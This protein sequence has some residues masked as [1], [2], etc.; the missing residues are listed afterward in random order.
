MLDKG[1]D[2]SVRISKDSAVDLV[3]LVVDSN[4]CA[5]PDEKGAKLQV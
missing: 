3:A 2:H 5:N 1:V 4:G